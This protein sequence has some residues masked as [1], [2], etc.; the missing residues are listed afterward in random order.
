MTAVTLFDA[1]ARARGGAGGGEPS[2]GEIVSLAHKLVSAAL[3]DLQRLRD[4]ELQCFAR[5]WRDADLH[6]N[7]TRSLHGLYQQW[8][9]DAEEVVERVRSLSAAGT[10]V[11]GADQLEEACGS[12]L[13]R[14]QLAPDQI[15]RGTAQARRGETVPG[16][17]LR[18]EL[19][20]RLRA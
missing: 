7:L 10:P 8:A 20:A 9:R 3:A 19:R 4:Y 1:F 17:V 12:V 14:L 5:D 6:R 11:A 18:N 15:E 13:A 16:E 2:D